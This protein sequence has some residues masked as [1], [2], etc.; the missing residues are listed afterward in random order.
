MPVRGHGRKVSQRHA[1]RQLPSWIR[2]RKR[3]VQMEKHS[4]NLPH[5]VPQS[6]CNQLPGSEPL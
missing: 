6:V 1:S 3:E 4:K 5:G 2:T